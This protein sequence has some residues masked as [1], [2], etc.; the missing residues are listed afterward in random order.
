MPAWTPAPSAT[1]SSGSRSRAARGRR[2][3]RTWRAHERDA[4]AAADQHD[5]VDVRR[6]DAGVARAPAGTGRASARRSARSAPR[7][8]R[9]SSVAAISRAVG[10][11]ERDLGRARVDESAHFA[12]LGRARSDLRARPRGCSRA[13]SAGSS[14]AAS[15]AIA[16]VDVVAAEPRVAVGRQHLEDAALAA[17]GSRCRR[18]RRRG[19]RPRPCPRSC[20]SRP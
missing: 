17:S 1:T 14:R 19:R 3:P 16:L 8:R 6:R 13:A 5:L 18:C 10:Q 15:S 2:A 20:W 12:L 9:A 7:T 11:R 4:R